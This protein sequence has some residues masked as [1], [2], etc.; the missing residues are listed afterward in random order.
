M[1]KTILS[2]CL[3]T[4]I[5][6]S[7]NIKDTF[8]MSI[9]GGKIKIFSSENTASLNIGYY[10]YDQN[11]YSINN[12]VYLNFNYIDSTADFYITNLKLDWIKNYSTF[13]PF[14]GLNIGYLYF[15]QNNNDYS[16]GIWGVQGGL[17][18]NLNDVFD[19]ELSATWQKAF[20]QT[21]IWSKNIKSASAGLIINF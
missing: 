17:I 16:A 3:L 21:D 15:N 1:K 6:F 20:E 11:K 14:V 5:A 18:I 8:F 4:T 2:L 12:R 10:F 7:G 9:K 13:S 19:I